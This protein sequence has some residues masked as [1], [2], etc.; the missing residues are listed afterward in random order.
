MNLWDVRFDKFN[1]MWGIE[2]TDSSIETKDCFLEQNITDVLIPGIGY[3]RNAKPFI[4][5]NME[6][7]GIQFILV[8]C[9]K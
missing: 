3:G 7:T 9:L 1:T 6:V 8:P 5:H 2:P 4:E